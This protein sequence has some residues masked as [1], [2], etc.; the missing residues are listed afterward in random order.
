MLNVSHLRGVII[1]LPILALVHSNKLTQVNLLLFLLL[2]PLVRFIFIQRAFPIEVCSF[3]SATFFNHLQRECVE[4]RFDID[5][6]VIV[7]I[8]LINEHKVRVD[9]NPTILTH[10]Y[11]YL[12]SEIFTSF[13]IYL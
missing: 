7:V 9:L 1:T 5:A 13:R 8:I 2:V 12:I 10:G 11:G 3:E 4:I 6:L